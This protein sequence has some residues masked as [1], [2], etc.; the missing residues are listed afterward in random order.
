MKMHFTINMPRKL[1]GN[2]SATVPCSGQS[3]LHLF[4]AGFEEVGMKGGPSMCTE[5]RMAGA[6]GSHWHGEGWAAR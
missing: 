5:L 6:G 1:I 2:K 4:D 3:C